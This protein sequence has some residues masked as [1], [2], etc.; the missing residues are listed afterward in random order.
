MLSRTIALLHAI[1]ERKD[2]SCSLTG[3]L[4]RIASA[5]QKSPV[6][7]DTLRS[8]AYGIFRTFDGLLYNEIEEEAFDL[9][10]D[11]GLL[12]QALE[13]DRT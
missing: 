9:V 5:L 4:T 7:I 6:D 12:V 11:I 8:D 13:D 10:G 3:A 1:E 2:F